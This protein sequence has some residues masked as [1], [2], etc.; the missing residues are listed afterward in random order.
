MNAKTENQ[1]AV[2][3]IKYYQQEQALREA[4]EW[5]NNPEGKENTLNFY[6]GKIETLR[7]K[8]NEISPKRLQEIDTQRANDC[9][10][11]EAEVIQE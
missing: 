3:L 8:L 11:N 7:K 5:D 6:K 10:V 9:T 2:E 1:I 4:T